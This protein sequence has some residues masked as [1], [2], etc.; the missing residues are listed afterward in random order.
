MEVALK[1]HTLS[2]DDMTIPIPFNRC[3]FKWANESYHQWFSAKLPKKIFKF[4][5]IYTKSEKC[6]I[7]ELKEI[8]HSEADF[9]YVDREGMVPSKSFKADGFTTTMRHGV[10]NNH[11]SLIRSNK[12]FLLLKD[13]LDIKDEE[14][15]LAVH[16]A[17]H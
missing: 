7:V 2:Y 16:A 17:Q 3:I 15:K 14:K 12:V 13:I 9:K 11:C 8:L 1:E 10:P 5:N 6:P 4:Y